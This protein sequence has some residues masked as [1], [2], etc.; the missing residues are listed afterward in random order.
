MS[1]YS[2]TGP[3]H[4]AGPTPPHSVPFFLETHFRPFSA[5]NFGS[6][7]DVVLGSKMTHFWSPKWT[8]MSPKGDPQMY[9]HNDVSKS[10]FLIVFCSILDLVNRR[11]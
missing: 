9:L 10:Q 6:I 1:K 11:K 3:A 2:P 4:S 5:L 8:Q 7:F